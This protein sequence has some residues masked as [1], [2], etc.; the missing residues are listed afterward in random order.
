MR[1]LLTVL[2]MLMPFMADAQT[3]YQK[4]K[5]GIATTG[6]VIQRGHMSYM[7][8][9]DTTISSEGTNGGGGYK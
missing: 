1:I 4:L 8:K 2:F 6:G 3:P 5:Y 7:T 9:L